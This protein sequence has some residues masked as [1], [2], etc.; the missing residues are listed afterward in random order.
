MHKGRYRIFILSLSLFVFPSLPHL[1]LHFL[2]LL[3][4]SLP[5]LLLNS[6]HISLPHHIS[7]IFAL[8][9]SSTPHPSSISLLPF[10]PSPYTY[11]TLSLFLPISLLFPYTYKA[12]LPLSRP[13]PPPPAPPPGPS[14]HHRVLRR[15]P[16]QGQAGDTRLSG[17]KKYFIKLLSKMFLLLRLFSSWLRMTAA[18]PCCHHCPQLWSRL[19]RQGRP[20]ILSTARKTVSDNSDQIYICDVMLAH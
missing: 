7:P 14:P 15:Q 6:S 17:I 9:I 13:P 12:S 16:G 10:L 11:P 2:L 5:A 1:S 3:P 4:L 19:R 8:T 18:A 20:A